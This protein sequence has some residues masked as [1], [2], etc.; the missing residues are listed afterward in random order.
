MSHR[1]LVLAY[2]GCDITTRDDLVAGRTHLKK[3]NN[4]YDWLGSGIY[5]YESDMERALAHAYAVNE[6]P[7]LQLASKAIASPAVVGVVLDVTRWLDMSTKLGLA[8]FETAATTYLHGLR[9]GGLPTPQNRAAFEGDTDML[10]RPFDKAVFDLIHSTRAIAFEEAMTKR[11]SVDL[12]SKLLPYQAIRSHFKQGNAISDSS[13]FFTK[14]HVQ[15]CLLDSSCIVSYFLPPSE[16][17]LS[18]QKYETAKVRLKAAEDEVR[19]LKP[20]K[21]V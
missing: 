14:N 16:K 15:I 3:S 17:L 6:R 10:H 5:F 11:K 2:H 21:R 12:L 1:N 20:R 19:R 18:E 13:G 8:E 9:N 4:S 7:E